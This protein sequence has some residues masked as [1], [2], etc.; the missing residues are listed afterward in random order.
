MPRTFVR[1]PQA[2][3]ACRRRK[4]KC[5]G[6]RP[7]C[8]RCT[9]RGVTCVWSTPDVAQEAQPGAAALTPK[10]TIGDEA[11]SPER[12]TEQG[13]KTCLDIFFQR[14]FTTD[15]SSFDHAPDFERKC[16]QSQLLAT[17]IIALCSRYLTT[18]EAQSLFGFASGLEVCK[19]YIQQAR[20]LAK[21]SSDQPSV[22]HIQ[23]NLILAQAELL[24]NSGSRHW[25]FA[26]TAIRMAEIMRLNK[27]FH[28]KHSLKEQEVRRRVFWA[29]V[30]LD[31]ALANFL[32]KH[33]TIDLG[34][35]EIPVPGTDISLV[36]QEETRGVMLSDLASYQR[37]SDLGLVPY[38]IRSICLWSDLADFTVYSR[39]RMD[40]FPPTDPESV[41]Y[42][43][44]S[45]LRT[46]VDSLH[47][48]LRWSIENF[49]SQCTLGQGRPF[50]SMHFVLYSAACAAHQCYLPHLAIYTQLCDLVDA[51]G[52]SYLHRD[53]SIIEVCVSNALKAG[54]MLTF[55]MNPEQENGLSSL[56][57]IWVASSVLVIANTFLWIQ[58]AQ[59]ETYSGEK[60]QEEAKSYFTLIQQLVSSWVPQWKAAKQWAMALDVMLAL[61][62]AAYL[63]EVHENILSPH[64]PGSVH[65]DDDGSDDFR[66]Q[67]GDGYPSIIS[68]PNLQ[69]SIKF[70]TGDTSARLT[71]IQS[72]WLQISG[73]WPFGF[74][75]P[76]CLMGTESGGNLDR[77]SI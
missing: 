11:D 2:C 1:T 34:N 29:C 62:K 22:S 52:W 59:D 51:A 6:I 55:L 74:T 14:H 5:D 16:R 15:F 53:Q 49:R 31:R 75:M 46:W 39:R 69:A 61:Y 64:G 42:K 12:N 67:P 4:S 9:S 57:T 7:R 32:A 71:D 17:C 44:Y 65:S 25:L 19:Y 30:L 24:S 66:P 18:Q 77:Y 47:P 68:L 60:I 41:I 73:D 13:L 76:E 33:R 72:I 26:G 20:S 3:D 37:P 38:L 50:V 70:A 58:Y 40:T 8:K 54:E 45:A 48:S 56:Q 27:D 23:G 36:Y 28:Q 35:I 21:E 10:S 43:R 63:G